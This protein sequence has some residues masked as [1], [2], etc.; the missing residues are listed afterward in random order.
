MLCVLKKSEFGNNFIKWVN[1]LSNNQ[2]SCVLNGGTTTKYFKLE[3]GASQG[4]PIY[5]Y[6]FISVV[7]FALIKS[8][9]LI[10]GIEIFDYCFLFTIYADVL[11]CLLGDSN[12]IN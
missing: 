10:K 6:L 9:E 4:D 12:S 2:E 3:T 11:T 1:V 7:L 8:L 5:A